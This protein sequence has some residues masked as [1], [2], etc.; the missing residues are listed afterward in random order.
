LR[1]VSVFYRPHAQSGLNTINPKRSSELSVERIIGRLWGGAPSS[2][3][4]HHELNF[5]GS[6]AF[7]NTSDAKHD[8][9]QKLEIIIG[10]VPQLLLLGNRNVC[11][12]E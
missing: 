3:D 11:E 9:D 2:A 1:K 12:S 10:Y 5:I 8:T 7:R 4:V 6:S